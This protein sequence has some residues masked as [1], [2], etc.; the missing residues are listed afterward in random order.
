MK[1]LLDNCKFP[2]VR[3]QF[4]FLRVPMEPEFLLRPA[5]PPPQMSGSVGNQNPGLS[6]RTSPP[7]FLSPLARGQRHRV[8]RGKSAKW[9][10]EQAACPVEEFN[11]ELGD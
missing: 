2:W 10:R 4:D 3:F 7:E 6:Q 11:S 5:P 8:G 9:G 1:L